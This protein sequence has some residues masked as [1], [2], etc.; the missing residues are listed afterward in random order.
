[1]QQLVIKGN[2]MMVSTRLASMRMRSYKRQ[3]YYVR[4]I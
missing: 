1:M 3:A 4:Q 2:D